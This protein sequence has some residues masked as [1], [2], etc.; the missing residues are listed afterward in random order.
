M[1]SV[2][3]WKAGQSEVK[4]ST[5][6]RNGVLILKSKSLGE[7]SEDKVLRKYKNVKAVYVFATSWAEIKNEMRKVDQE[8][9][10]KAGV[11]E[12]HP[13]EYPK[14][15][16]VAYYGCTNHAQIDN[17]AYVR[18]DANNVAYIFVIASRTSERNQ[19]E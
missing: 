16:C 4:C 15:M 17:V 12:V 8:F 1:A 19:Y 2:R 14:G 3:E 7:G 11:G 9:E 10:F 6:Y 18:V 13:M 5:T